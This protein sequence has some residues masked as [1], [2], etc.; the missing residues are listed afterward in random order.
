MNQV[1]KKLVEVKVHCK[2]LKIPKY[3]RRLSLVGSGTPPNGKVCKKLVEVKVHC[4]RTVSCKDQRRLS[5]VGGGTPTNGK[6]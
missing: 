2:A 6:D 4:K 1:Y 3:Q 5:L